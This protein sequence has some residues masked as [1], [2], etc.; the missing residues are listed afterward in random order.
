MFSLYFLLIFFWYVNFSSSTTLH[1]YHQTTTSTNTSVETTSTFFDS[2]TQT[3]KQSINFNS[4]SYN[5]KKKFFLFKKKTWNSHLQKVSFHF[6]MFCSVLFCAIPEW[7]S[8]SH[9]FFD[10]LNEMKEE[11]GKKFEARKNIYEIDIPFFNAYLRY[12]NSFRKR[13]RHIIA[14]WVLLLLQK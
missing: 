3:G 14:I 12:R 6:I 4:T 1:H 5:I 9:L 10:T 13:C 8:K 7:E 2:S 11:K